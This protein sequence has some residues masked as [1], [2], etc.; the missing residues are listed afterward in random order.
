MNTIL[1]F[2]VLVI[3]GIGILAYANYLN[4]HHKEELELQKKSI[5][6][7]VSNIEKYMKGVKVSQ[8]KY[9]IYYINMDKHV[10]RRKETEQQLSKISDKFTR[11]LGVDGYKINNLRSDKVD[12][13]SFINEYKGMTKGEMGC[14]LSHI[15]A[16][17]TSF[18]NGDEIAMICEDDIYTEPYKMSV[19]LEEIVRNTPPDWE[20][21][22]LYSGGVDKSVLDF[23]DPKNPEYLK[24]N[25]NKNWSTVA[26]LI[27]R[28]GMEKLLAILGC[29]WN[30]RPIG[31]YDVNSCKNRD[32]LYIPSKNN[33]PTYGKADIW[34]PSILK[35]YVVLPFPFS[36][37][38]KADSTIHNDHTDIYHLPALYTFFSVLN[39][40][41]SDQKYVYVETNYDLNFVS[42]V[43]PHYLT[44]RKDN[45]SLIVTNVLSSD[46]SKRTKI[47][48]II[49][50]REPWD[51][52]KITNAD[53][54]ITTKSHPKNKLN[55][56]Y[57]PQYSFSFSEYSISPEILLLPKPKSMKTKFCAFVYSNCN[58]KY[59][60]VE[61]REK[62][63]DL[64]Q[65]AS[66]NRVH[67]WGKCK[68]NMKKK[69][70]KTNGYNNSSSFLPYK[71]VIA[72]END[73]PDG[74]ISEKITNP[75]LAGSIPIYLGDKDIGAHFNKKSFIDVRDFPSWEKCVEYVLFLDSND[76][77][78]EKMYNEPWLTGNKLTKHF[79]WWDP[80]LGDFYEKL[81]S[82]CDANIVLDENDNEVNPNKELF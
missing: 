5:T 16:I 61:A 28:S 46:H 34:I 76:A 12:N 69:E 56:I 52:S 30:I 18:D 67:S 8:V 6:I 27:R 19:S 72:F 51:D 47:P 21:L 23:V 73:Y 41:I 45:A 25:H 59:K 14:L 32:N 75:M 74:Y 81:N 66:G 79:S 82:V 44:D 58:K 33:Y 35:S 13:I 77:E 48:K 37:H 38:P 63:F 57:V 2:S 49:I 24:Y 7:F 26:Y 78:Y 65:K 54:L 36:T 40:R 3:I 17:Q 53:L 42:H 60:G 11:I 43:L 31:K 22:Q 70:E 64:I 50:D 10:E 68:N 62:F 71:F 39:R 9:P 29:P 20:W 15:R 4:S 55:F 80:S 1:V